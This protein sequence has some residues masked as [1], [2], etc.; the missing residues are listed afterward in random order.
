MA[1]A[2]VALFAALTV[3]VASMF[4]TAQVG[5]F[6]VAWGWGT[7]AGAGPV[8]FGR[9]GPVALAIWWALVWANLGAYDQR[10]SAGCRVPGW[11]EK[12][13]GRVIRALLSFSPPQIWGDTTFSFLINMV[14]VNVTSGQ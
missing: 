7:L 3:L 11:R 14:F 8:L 10:R 5:W 13:L 2:Q 1:L 6:F 9:A 4:F 12:R